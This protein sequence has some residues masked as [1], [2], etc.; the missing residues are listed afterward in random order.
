VRELAAD[1]RRLAR[2]I[3][4]RSRGPDLL[5]ALAPLQDR[6]PE[7]ASRVCQRLE[8][9]FADAEWNELVVGNLRESSS[10]SFASPGRRMTF[11]YS[12]VTQHRRALGR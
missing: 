1:A 6:I 2:A 3:S 11:A 4:T 7:A 8:V 10:R 5:A 12:V 9:I